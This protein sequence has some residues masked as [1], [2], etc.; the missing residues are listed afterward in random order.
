M[1]LRIVLVEIG[2]IIAAR[3]EYFLIQNNAPTKRGGGLL[4]LEVQQTN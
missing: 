3:V 2:R 4:S 1:K